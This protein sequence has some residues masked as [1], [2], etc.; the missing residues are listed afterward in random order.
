M[1]RVSD[2]DAD[3]MTRRLAQKEGI[4]ADIS[5]GAAVWAALKISARSGKGKSDLIKSL[6]KITILLWYLS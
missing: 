4:L 6:D 5:P 1:L 3:E 2:D